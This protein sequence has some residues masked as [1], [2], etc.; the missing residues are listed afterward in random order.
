MMTDILKKTLTDRR[1]WVFTGVVGLIFSALT[2]WG[3]ALDAK[4]GV[5]FLGQ[6]PEIL[7]LTPVFAL[8]ISLIWLLL[9]R[10]DRAEQY[11]IDQGFRQMRV[12]LHG[13]MARIELLPEDSIVA[14]TSSA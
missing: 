13:E 11:L 4:G 5:D 6:L 9:E 3:R 12:R 10:I 2:S 7:M 1:R 8:V 14:S